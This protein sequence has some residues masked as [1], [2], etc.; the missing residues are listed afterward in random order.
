MHVFQDIAVTVTLGQ[1]P[2]RLK[3]LGLI[4]TS[5]SAFVV[6]SARTIVP[7]QLLY[8]SLSAIRQSTARFYYQLTTVRP[9]AYVSFPIREIIQ[10]PKPPV[11][12]FFSSSIYISHGGVRCPD[13]T[14]GCQ[15]RTIDVKQGLLCGCGVLSRVSEG[16]ARWVFLQAFDGCMSVDNPAYLTPRAA[17]SGAILCNSSGWVVLLASPLFLPYCDNMWLFETWLP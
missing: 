13:F 14:R 8:V 16:S 4:S 11:R 6:L 2:R 10:I 9:Q 12:C 17:F 3:S 1:C 5:Y 7:G 15:R